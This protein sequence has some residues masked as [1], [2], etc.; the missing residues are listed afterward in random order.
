[1]TSDSHGSPDREGGRPKSDE[2]QDPGAY[3]GHEPER[4]TETIPGGLSRKDERVAAVATQSTGG[5]TR[6]DS[7]PEGHREGEPGDDDRRREAGDRD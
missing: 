6:D 1:M 5:E 7:W 3:I 4:A 2:A